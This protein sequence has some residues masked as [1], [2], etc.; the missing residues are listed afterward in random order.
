MTELNL[1]SDDF[2]NSV[3]QTKNRERL[4]DD[5]RERENMFAVHCSSI[6]PFPL[7][8]ETSVLSPPSAT[9]SGKALIRKTYCT[10]EIAVPQHFHCQSTVSCSWEECLS[11]FI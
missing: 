10:G 5:I 9:V 2:R 6:C 1:T 11:A 3:I 4:K 7:G 8:I